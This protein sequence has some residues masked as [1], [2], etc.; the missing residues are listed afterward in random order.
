MRIGVDASRLAVQAR[1]GTE[2]YT[3]E[4]LN[5]LGE[6]DRRNN[7]VLYCNRTPA[8][9]PPL[10]P[11]FM[12]KAMPLPRAWTHGRLSL[13]MLRH[14]PDVLFVPAHALPVITGPRSVVTIH[15][16][17]FLHHPEAHTRIQRLYHR[18][19]TRLSARRA[20]HIVA[21]SEATRRDI[22]H[23]YG[24]PA[25]KIS[26]VYHGVHPRFHPQTD[27]HKLEATLER[28]RITGSYLLFVST[29]QPRKNVA[30]LL[31]AFAAARATLASG[32]LPTLVLAGKRGWL[33]EQIER[34]AAE[35]DIAHAVQ[36]IG[37]VP[38]ADLPTLLS[39]ALAYINPSLYEG[40]GMTV[41]EAQAC[42]TPV[43]AAN[44]SSLPEV[45]GDAG[46]L[47]DPHDVAALA[48]GLVRLI[49]DAGLR[50][51]LRERGLRH[52]AGWTWER[53]A[54]E[55]LAILERVGQA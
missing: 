21:I 49:V 5:A 39:G 6:V 24:I 46:I 37:Y 51:Q 3:W 2:H 8:A 34:R 22:E 47:V 55:T 10:P 20:T 35:L 15:D 31:E 4:L 41:L 23:F 7:Y 38:D 28:Y 1:T 40:F 11:T 19:F 52:V 48:D 29:V 18:F 17:G 25:A 42:G 32:T 44:T 43:L 12:L 50:A 27:R 54:R 16:L 53:T 13:E 26:V 36:F 9:L 45:V 30:R 14:P 33:T